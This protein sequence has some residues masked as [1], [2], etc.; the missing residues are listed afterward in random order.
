MPH[1]LLVAALVAGSDQPPSPSPDLALSV[2]LPLAAADAVDA[3]SADV[4]SAIGSL[5]P[6]RR[7]FDLALDWGLA[8]IGPAALFPQDQPTGGKGVSPFGS[9]AGGS[10]P[11]ALAATGQPDSVPSSSPVPVPEPTAAGAWLVAAAVAAARKRRAAAAQRKA[12]RSGRRC[13]TF[14]ARTP[15]AGH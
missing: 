1:P 9:G 5:V 8:A 15:S 11:S 13:P 2:Q 10:S 4:Q 14:A 3:S 12:R 7:M 6:D